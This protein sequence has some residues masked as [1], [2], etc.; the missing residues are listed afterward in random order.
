MIPVTNEGE[1]RD[2]FY[3]LPLASNW[4]GLMPEV[5]APA[6][7]A[8]RRIVERTLG[9]GAGGTYLGM[10]SSREASLKFQ[11]AKISSTVTIPERSSGPNIATR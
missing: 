10:V 5:D 4:R 9:S 3:V 11:D 7:Y 8:A 2:I 1:I 6:D